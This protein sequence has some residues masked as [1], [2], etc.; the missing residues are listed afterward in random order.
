MA[1]TIDEATFT[2]SEAAVILDSLVAM[3]DRLRGG[4]QADTPNLDSAIGKLKRLIGRPDSNG[5]HAIA[6]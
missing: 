2:D 1:R 4:G 3:R 6:S 5:F